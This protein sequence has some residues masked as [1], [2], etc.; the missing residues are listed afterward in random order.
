MPW[1]YWGLKPRHKTWAKAWQRELQAHL[2]DMET[3]TIGE[4]SFIAP[5]A[6]LFAEPGRAI[7]VGNNS[8]IAAD[9][10]LHGPIVIG[11]NVSVN[12]H[13]TL[14]GGKRG[15][16]IGDYS[17]I[18]CYA[19]LFAFNHGQSLNKPICEQTVASKGINLGQDVW[20][21]AGVCIVDGVNIGD[22]AIVGMGSVV[23]K[24]VATSQKVAGNPAAPIG[25]RA[26]T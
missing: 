14:D 24:T 26:K 18:A 9:C 1:L 21:G 12:H 2:Q 8:F 11:D 5:E 23:T 19:K 16:R 17:R 13:C 3:V 6:K 22:H 4:N 15:I 25:Y 7:V 20:L 10:L